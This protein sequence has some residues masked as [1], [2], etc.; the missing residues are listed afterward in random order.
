MTMH[1]IDIT[2]IEHANK[3]DPRTGSR[4]TH[5]RFRA[6]RNRINLLL[7]SMRSPTAVSYASTCASVEPVTTSRRAEMPREESDRVVFRSAK[8][9]SLNPSSG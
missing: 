9:C 6:P 2:L 7:E 5:D 8:P 4:G 1:K 3:V